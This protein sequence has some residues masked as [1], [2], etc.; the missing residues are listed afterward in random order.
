MKA[1][2]TDKFAED[3]EFVGVYSDEEAAMQKL[4]E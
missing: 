1:V 4:N 2:I 3:I